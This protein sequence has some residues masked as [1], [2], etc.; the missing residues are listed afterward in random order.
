MAWISHLPSVHPQISLFLR[1]T[2]VTDA[3]ILH[4]HTQT[5]PT[6]TL[7]WL[8]KIRLIDYQ[9][10]LLLAAFCHCHCSIALLKN[11]WTL[12]SFQEPASP[13]KN[14]L[15]TRAE[16]AVSTYE[17][18]CSA[19]LASVTREWKRPT[20]TH[21]SLTPAAACHC[22]KAVWPMLS[23]NKDFVL[24]SEVGVRHQALSWNNF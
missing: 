12:E 23:K 16:N 4:R 11:E 22:R 6:S 10:L 5:T 19:P 3:Y 8:N 18:L 24:L 13:K 9:L 7:N 1:Y 21:H 14:M 2:Q 20:P 15:V 17:M